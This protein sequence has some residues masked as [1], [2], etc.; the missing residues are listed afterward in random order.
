MFGWKSFVFV[1]V[2]HLNFYLFTRLCRNSDPCGRFLFFRVSPLRA[3]HFARVKWPNAF[4]PLYW[5]FGLP[6]SEVGCCGKLHFPANT[7][8]AKSPSLQHLTASTVA[9]ESGIGCRGTHGCVT[10]FELSNGWQISNG[11]YSQSLIRKAP[12]GRQVGEKH[13]SSICEHTNGLALQGETWKRRLN[14][15]W[16]NE[17]L[18]F[19]YRN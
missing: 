10:Q 15:K 2:F 4:L 12:V 14:L 6:T 7:E 16:R 13:F 1:V 18:T 9:V 8:G 3:S 17:L 19:R 5:P 11:A